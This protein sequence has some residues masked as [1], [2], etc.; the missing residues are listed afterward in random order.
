[1][2]GSWVL[3]ARVV[4]AV[5]SIVAIKLLATYLSPAELGKWAL[6]SGV[7]ALMS[8]VLGG[9]LNQGIGRFA[10][11]AARHGSLSDLVIRGTLLHAVC[12]LIATVPVGVWLWSGASGFD[13]RPSVLLAWFVLASTLNGTYALASGLLNILRLRDRW[14]AAIATEGIVR[15]A[16]LGGLLATTATFWI[17]IQAMVVGAVAGILVASLTLQ[18]RRSGSPQLFSMWRDVFRFGGP[19]LAVNGAW[20]VLTTSNRYVLERVDGL[21]EVGA[22][23]VAGGTAMALMGTLDG[24]LSSTTLPMLYSR[25]PESSVTESE[26]R[27]NATAV[28]SMQAVL[29]LSAGLPFLGH[30]ILSL[31]ASRRYSHLAL[32]F[33]LCLTAEFARSISGHLGAVFYARRAPH[34]LI[35]PVVIGAGLQVLVAV[36]AMKRFGIWGAPLA[37][38]A[39]YFTVLVATL[40]RTSLWRTQHAEWRGWLVRLAIVTIAGA[41]LGTWCAA[42]QPIDPVPAALALAGYGL[43]AACSVIAQRRSWERLLR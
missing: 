21:S 18:L 29:L 6:F 31:L 35:R 15:L 41:V 16:V 39:G 30:A 24:M 32:L 43:V 34:L 17:P 42:R 28:V 14:A 10:N 2:E 5:V 3:L 27:G 8:G 37:S 23:A 38:A 11:E 12:V 26:E 7:V 33:G 9:V 36:I 1:M 40:M 4:S 13:A 20:W 22:Y 19:L 25:L